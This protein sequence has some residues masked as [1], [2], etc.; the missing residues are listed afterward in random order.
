MIH[1]E[2]DLKSASAGASASSRTSTTTSTTSTATASASSLSHQPDQPTPME[3]DA[4]DLDATIGPQTSSESKEET[5]SN[6]QFE[7]KNI[8]IAKLKEATNKMLTLLGIDAIDDTKIRGKKYQIDTM[9]KLTNRLTRSLFP[10]AEP[11]NDAEQIIHQLKHKF[12][13]TID[14]NLKIKVLS[15]LP[16]NWSVRKIRQVF[17]E[18]VPIRMI[19]KT[20]EIVEKNGILCDTTKK[21]ASHVIDPN[22]VDKVIDFY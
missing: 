18:E 21:I 10:H 12:H 17:G 11:S 3:L 5:D 1:V 4:V 14:R 6:E 20:K 15:V 9:K 8:D 13:N 7:P 19:K 22:T 2:I 16:K